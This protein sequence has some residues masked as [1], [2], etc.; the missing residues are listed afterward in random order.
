MENRQ[1]S[2]VPAWGKTG[3]T[4]ATGIMVL[5]L[6]ASISFTFSFWKD[7]Y[8]RCMNRNAEANT[9]HGLTN[10]NLRL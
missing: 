8:S 1:K 7:I 5:L 6:I 4:I 9:W 10:R 3:Y 2:I